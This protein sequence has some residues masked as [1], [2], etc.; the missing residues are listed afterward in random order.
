MS[1]AACGPADTAIARSVSTVLTTT[2]VPYDS[3][4]STRVVAARLTSAMS[5]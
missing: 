4:P 3:G 5:A 1:T 2:N